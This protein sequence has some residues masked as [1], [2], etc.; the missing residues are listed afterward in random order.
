MTEP[1][2]VFSV[3]MI[4]CD[5]GQLGQVW[6]YQP[7]VTREK[8][9]EVAKE[10]TKPI[11]YGDGDATYGIDKIDNIVGWACWRPRIFVYIHEAV[12]L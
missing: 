5:G 3:F 2:K 10:W 11:S 7:C 1:V 6:K 8:A 12:L 9:E 4:S